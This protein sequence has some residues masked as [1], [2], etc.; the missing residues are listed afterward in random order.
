VD[1]APSSKISVKV[2]QSDLDAIA[3]GEDVK[4]VLMEKAS[5][6]EN[7]FGSV[8][9]LVTGVGFAL[10]FGLVLSKR[11]WVMDAMLGASLRNAP[12]NS[13][14]YSNGTSAMDGLQYDAGLSLRPMS[15]F[16]VFKGLLVGAEMHGVEGLQTY[17]MG[18]SW[19]FG[20]DLSVTPKVGFQVGKINALGNFSDVNIFTTGFS[21]D[22]KAMKLA[23]SYGLGTDGRSQFGFGLDFGYEWGK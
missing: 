18:L 10:D 12:A 20:N 17:H 3:G 7:M 19:K 2:D 22:L 6:L 16:P 5:G 11:F 13:I 9:E 1:Y 14:S 15:T 21:V 8:P 23:A 4:S